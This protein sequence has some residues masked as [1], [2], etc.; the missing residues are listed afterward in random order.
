MTA[1]KYFYLLGANQ[2]EHRLTC[3]EVNVDRIVDIIPRDEWTQVNVDRIFDI[4]P[5][6]EWTQVNVDRIVDAS[7]TCFWRHQCQ[8]S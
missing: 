1:L 4:I 7:E 6:D 2:K 5:R 8:I 3:T